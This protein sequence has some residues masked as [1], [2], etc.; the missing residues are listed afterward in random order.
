MDPEGLRG[1]NTGVY[2]GIA[3][4]SEYRDLMMDGLDGI[5]YLGTA[6]SMAIGGV[7]F[8]LGLMGPTMPV[9]LNC[10]AS[11]VAVHHAV[12]ALRQ[13]EVDLALVGGVN[14]IFSPGLT[15]EM[16]ELRML[17]PEGRCKTFD[18]SADGFVRSE[19]CGMV[20]LKRL[21]EAEADGDRILGRDPGV[22]GQPERGNRRADGAEWPSTAAR[23]RR[24][25][26]PWRCCAR[27][28][29]LP[30]STRSRLR[31][32]RPDRGAGRGRSLRSGAR[33]GPIRC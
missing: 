1:S 13:G 22:R 8:K 25:A 32:G 17:S 7:A 21:G 31:A 27:P 3:G 6:G 19:G 24:G 16:A 28:G 33:A 10:A 18:A 5:N 26:R 23:D 12:G 20:V 4:E 2:A 15:R 11:L 30:G 29:R 14:A 9:V